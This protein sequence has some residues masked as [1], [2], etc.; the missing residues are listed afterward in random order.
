[1]RPSLVTRGRGCCFQWLSP[2]DRYTNR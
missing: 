2:V 1:M